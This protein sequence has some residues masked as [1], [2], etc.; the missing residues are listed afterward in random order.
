[1]LLLLP[2]R[3][4]RLR[5]GVL[6]HDVVLVRSRRRQ[7]AQVAPALSVGVGKPLAV[8]HGGWRAPQQAE[9]LWNRQHVESRCWHPP[10]QLPVVA[11]VQSFDVFPG[12]NDSFHST[13]KIVARMR[14]SV[15]GAPPPSPPSDHCFCRRAEVGRVKTAADYVT[16]TSWSWFVALAVAAQALVGAW[17]DCDVIAGRYAEPGRALRRRLVTRHVGHDSVCPAQDT[18]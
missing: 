16:W 13:S 3:R 1:M 8:D 10:P 15:C 4:L 6:E 9:R 17:A 5:R 14:R 11:I 2:L 12:D 18:H 7:F